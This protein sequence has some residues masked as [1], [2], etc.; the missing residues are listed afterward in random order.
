MSDDECDI[1]M[2]IADEAGDEEKEEEEVPACP[3]SGQVRPIFESVYEVPYGMMSLLWWVIGR[4]ICAA[5][6]D[7]HA[8]PGAKDLTPDDIK[9]M[10]DVF[11]L[12]LVTA[13]LLREHDRVCC[14]FDV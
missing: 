14:D 9:P 12:C 7:P 6:E 3:A 4:V 11:T 1:A 2:L 5:K 10:N 8:D 13:A